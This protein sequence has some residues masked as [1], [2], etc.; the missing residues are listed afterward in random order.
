MQSKYKLRIP[1]DLADFVRGA[2]PALKTKIKSALKRILSDPYSGKSLREELKGLSSY[3]IGRFRII[4]RVASN[5]VIEIVAIGPRRVIYE[6][7]YRIVKE[8]G[9]KK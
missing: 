2:H 9:D 8:E 1:A 6:I 7:T 4:Y 3:R 5:H